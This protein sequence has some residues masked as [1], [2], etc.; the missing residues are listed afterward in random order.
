MA[1]VE[2]TSIHS[3]QRNYICA[4]SL[5]HQHRHNR[6]LLLRHI[7]VDDRGIIFCCVFRHSLGAAISGVAALE[8]VQEY[9]NLTVNMNKYVEDMLLPMMLR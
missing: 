4:L 5:L 1:W 6:V 3:H 7:S 8:I 2:R 9:K